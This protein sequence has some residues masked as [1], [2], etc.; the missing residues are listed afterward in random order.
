MD[1]FRRNLDAYDQPLTSWQ[2]YT[3]KGGDSLDRLAAKH[4]IALSKLKLA[5]GITS[6][7]KVGP[8]SQLLLP[9]KGSGVGAEPLPAV[10][11]PPVQSAPRRGGLVHIVRKGETLYGI[12]RRYR[13]STDS[14]LRWNHVGVLTTGQRLI[15]YRAPGKAR[16][17]V[18]PVK[19][20]AGQPKQNVVAT[21]AQP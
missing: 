14:L 18:N 4:A 17:P 9:L 6:R 2:P 8:G 3:M 11:R 5:N 21:L 1:A 15:I 16:K 20:S 12:S 7:T 13:V 10:F 19:I